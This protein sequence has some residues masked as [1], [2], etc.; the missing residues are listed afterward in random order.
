MNDHSIPLWM[1]RR[2]A[3]LGVA[4]AALVVG[5]PTA[6]TQPAPPVAPRPL[7]EALAA[8]IPRAMKLEGTPGLNIALALDGTVI[9]EAGFGSADLDRRIPMTAATVTHSGSMGKTYTGTAAMQL[10]EQGVIGLNDPI[11]KFITD[12]RIVNPLGEREIT[13]LDL[14]THRSGLASNS[15]GSTFAT[16]EPLGDWLRRAYASPA[17]ESYEGTLSPRWTARVGEKLQYSNLGIATLG[18][19]VQVANPEKLSF[20]DYVQRHIMDPLGMRSSQ[21]PPVQDKAHVRADLVARFS[22][23]YATLGG[24]RLPTPAIYFADFPA[25]TVVTTPGDHIRLLLAYLNEGRYNGHQLLK[26]ETVRL[27]LTPQTKRAEGVDIG[28][29]WN[30]RNVGKPS[31]DFSHGGAHMYGWTND[32]RAYPEQRLAIAIFTNHW[33]ISHPRYHEHDLIARFAATWVERARAG[34]VQTLRPASWA[35][36]TSYVMGLIMGEQLKPA[37][38]TI[39]EVTPAM[40]SA[41]AAGARSREGGRAGS[42]LWNAEAF[43]LGVTDLLSVQPQSY[44]AIRAFMASDRLRIL[45][46]ELELINRELGV[47]G[48]E[49]SR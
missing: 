47:T 16:P 38:G 18:Y 10:V 49:A 26:P 25:G 4:A 40:L 24:I 6:A 17:M 19:L 36:K 42:G 1:K 22:T 31:F 33:P 14:L 13:V 34:A 44:A 45:P 29:V 43:R 30:L 48:T 5:A 23:G 15:A 11:S 41:M 7:I 37:L 9:W 27:M 46:Q 3:A 20:S 39:G 12:V 2:A 35:W 28:L 21:Y 8:F 32:F